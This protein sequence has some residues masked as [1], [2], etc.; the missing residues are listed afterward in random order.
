MA[1]AVTTQI[2]EDG[3]RTAIVVL[4]NLSD[5]TGESAITK[6]DPALLSTGSQGQ[7]CTGVRIAKVDFD[8]V[9]MR[10]ILAWHATSNVTALVLQ[11]AADHF[12]LSC[13]GGITNNA[14]AGKDGKLLL[15]TGGQTLGASYSIILELVKV[16]D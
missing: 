15:T 5:G 10:V 12:D 16:Y 2:V 14:G 7:A 4:T 1:D 13:F 11:G 9:G 8:I 3:H 6:V